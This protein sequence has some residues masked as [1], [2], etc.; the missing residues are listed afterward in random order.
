MLHI[1]IH[2]HMY[3]YLSPKLRHIVLVFGEPG[4]EELQRPLAPPVHRLTVVE[5]VTVFVDGVVGQVHEVLALMH[6]NVL[7]LLRLYRA[8]RYGTMHFCLD[9][10]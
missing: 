3:M 4:V 2:M 5:R 9:N 10:L 1:I 6:E 8:N 7:C